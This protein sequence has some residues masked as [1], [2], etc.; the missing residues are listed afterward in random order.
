MSSHQICKEEVVPVNIDTVT[1]DTHFGQDIRKCCS[2]HNTIVADLNSIKYVPNQK[3][4]DNYIREKSVVRC[5]DENVTW[6]EHPLDVNGKMLGAIIIIES[7]DDKILLV[8]NRKLWGLPKGARNYID[9]MDCKR[10]T[11]KVFRDTGTI[12]SHKEAQFTKD[13]IESAIDNACREVKEET[14]ITIDPDNIETVD[15]YQM[16][17]RCSYDGFYYKYPNHAS[18]HQNELLVNG[19]DHENDELL[20]VSRSD[21]KHMLHDHRSCNHPKIFNHITYGLLEYFLR[22]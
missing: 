18:A 4:N 1:V 9:F 19:T 17:N 8:R 11:D 22:K 21:L 5:Y 14:G 3:R 13:R 15:Y 12:I 20:W 6:P 7:Q 16:N 2:Y 10:E